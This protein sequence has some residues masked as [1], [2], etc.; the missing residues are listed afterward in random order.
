MAVVLLIGAGPLAALM[1]ADRVFSDRAPGKS[2]RKAAVP[3]PSSTAMEEGASYWAKASD[4]W[5]L[6]SLGAAIN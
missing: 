6:N 3:N 1:A 5:T 4:L 2:S